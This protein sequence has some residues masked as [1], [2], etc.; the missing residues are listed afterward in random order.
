MNAWEIQWR[1]E[2]VKE[3]SEKATCHPHSATSK[4]SSSHSGLPFLSFLFPS[5]R[6]VLFKFM[7]RYVDDGWRDT[8]DGDPSDFSTLPPVM[9][10]L[11]RRHY[12]KMHSIDKQWWPITG[13]SS[14][15]LRLFGPTWR[16]IRW[17]NDLLGR[18]NGEKKSWV[19]LLSVNILIQLIWY[20]VISLWFSSLTMLGTRNHEY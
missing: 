5:F 9:Y 6:Q 3:W 20:T 16:T 18:M 14:V 8:R 4:L 19:E 1:K 10:C 12:W 13:C 17:K 15:W 2:E 11:W 7:T